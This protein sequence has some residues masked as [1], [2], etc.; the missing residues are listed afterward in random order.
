MRIV[1]VAHSLLNRG[2]DRMVLAHA[3]WLASHGHEVEL[4]CNIV[5]T[6]LDI[7]EGVRFSRPFLPGVLGSVVSALLQRRDADVVLA[8][9]IPMACFLYPRSGRKV[10]YFAQ[11]YNES[12]YTSLMMRGLVRLFNHVGLTLCRI[13]II[14]VSGHLAEL[15]RKRFRARVLVAENGVDTNVFYPDP[16]PVLVSEKGT[17]KALLLFSRDDPGKGFDIAREVVRRLSSVAAGLF[18]VWTVGRNCTWV[19]DGTLQLDFGYVG[20]G[21][22]RQIMSSAD[23]FLYPT[24]HEGFGLMPLEAFACRCPVVTTAAVTFASHMENALVAKVGDTERLAELTLQA[25]SGSAEIERLAN[26]GLQT[27]EKMSLGRSQAQFASALERMTS[28]VWR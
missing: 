1:Y 24:R 19:G 17:R 26:N 6:V 10:V 21:R 28:G 18:E 8:S 27:A 20:E 12:F 11:D 23:I 15:L 13:P 3:G 4:C 7:P 22:L 14:A 16:D 5:D 9:I 25:I 2:G